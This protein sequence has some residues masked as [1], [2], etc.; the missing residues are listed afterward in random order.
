MGIWCPNP[1]GIVDELLC[2]LM[3]D[4]SRLVSV[5]ENAEEAPASSSGQARPKCTQTCDV[6]SLEEPVALRRLFK[7]CYDLTGRTPKRLLRILAEYTATENE[8]ITLL[9]WSSKSHRPDTESNKQAGLL[10]VLRMFP[11]CRPPLAAFINGLP[12]MKP[13]YYSIA[14]SPFATPGVAAIAFSVVPGG[15]C[16]PWLA[17]LC[18][19]ASG[20]SGFSQTGHVSEQQAQIAVFMKRTTVFT[21]PADERKPVLM[22]G[23]GTGV[24]P[25][26]GFIQHRKYQFGLKRKI[27]KSMSSN[28]NL[29]QAGTWGGIDLSLI[30]GLE[31]EEE[32]IT[33]CCQRQGE[34]WLFFGCRHANRD[35][36]Y[37]HELERAL[38]TD[39]LQKLETAFSRDT[40]EKV[41]VQHKIERYGA[42]VCHLLLDA[43]GYFFVC[44]DGNKMAKDVRLTLQSVFMKHRGMSEKDAKKQIA[45]MIKERKFVMDIWSV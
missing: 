19:T 30:D 8:R 37:R 40:S 26:R 36:L 3:F 2:H 25:F 28:D 33:Q 21:L 32:A 42:E 18:K 11:S 27:K 43:G 6:D 22:V 23:P 16:T 45:T 1:D 20:V 44:G 14:S 31:E 4:P 34:M 5:A 24:S 10:E 15:H 17:T 35:Y 12:A 29:A 39:T 41:Y 9:R 13:R 7:W 38:E